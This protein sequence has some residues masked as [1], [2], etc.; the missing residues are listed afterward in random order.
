MLRSLLLKIR[1]KLLLEN[2]LE[3]PSRSPRSSPVQSPLPRMSDRMSFF[4][5]SMDRRARKTAVRVTEPRPTNPFNRQLSLQSFSSQTNRSG[6]SSPSLSDYTLDDASLYSFDYDQSRATRRRFFSHS[7]KKRIKQ[8]PHVIYRRSKG[9]DEESDLDTS[10]IGSSISTF[11]P[12]HKK[13]THKKATGDFVVAS[14]IKS[15]HSGLLD[16][17]EED[18][19]TATPSPT[20]FL[21]DLA[22]SKRTSTETVIEILDETV[23]IPMISSSESDTST[24][25]EEDDQSDTS[26]IYNVLDETSS[27][28]ERDKEEKVKGLEKEGSECR[29]LLIKSDFVD[30]LISF[31]EVPVQ[32]RHKIRKATSESTLSVVPPMSYTVENEVLKVE[33]EPGKKSP[34]SKSPRRVER[35]NTVIYRGPSKTDLE[36]IGKEEVP[37]IVSTIAI[38]VDPP[39]EVLVSPSKG[40]IEETLMLKKLEKKYRRRCMADL[41]NI[42]DLKLMV[43]KKPEEVVS[44]P[45]DVAKELERELEAKQ[46]V[47]RL[48]SEPE[49]EGTESQ[50]ALRELP[51]SLTC[52]DRVECAEPFNTTNLTDNLCV[53]RPPSPRQPEDIANSARSSPPP[54][55]ATP[56]ATKHVR[57]ASVRTGPVVQIHR[58]SSDSDLS[59]TTKG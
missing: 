16:S 9:S 33:V 39:T 20:R 6:D 52:S 23:P 2:D 50:L 44:E 34:R 17:V 29:E 38:V 25:D 53:S 28:Q 31:E 51:R 19:E 57:S 40:L 15:L 11:R 1:S 46:A 18:R 48:K 41:I 3:S 14:L 45:F 22:D 10:S 8:L 47:E 21:G 26:A 30:E 27:F 12:K 59:V 56:T 24:E 37:S 32:N 42:I 36:Q 13:L 4:S 55:Q 35:K 7:L 54:L 49:N 5:R 43:E 58:R